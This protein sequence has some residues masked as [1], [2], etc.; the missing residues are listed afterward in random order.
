MKNLGIILIVIGVVMMFI[1]GF[2]YFTKEEVAELGPLEISK[3]ESHPVRWSP[4]IG[5]VLVIGGLVMFLAD[6]KKAF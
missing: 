2:N 1:T 4:I 3:Q 6:R 5:G